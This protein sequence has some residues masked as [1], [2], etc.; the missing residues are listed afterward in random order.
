MGIFIQS[1]TFTPAPEGVHQAVCCDVVD[2]GM[3]SSVWDGEEKK[4]H[5]LRLSFQIDVLNGEGKPF[6]VS[7]KLTASTHEKAKMVAF[8]N[9]WRG[10]KMTDQEW[11]T[12]DLETLIGVNCM[13]QIIHNEGK[14]GN[15]YAN[16]Q[17]IMPWQ[18]KMGEPIQVRDYTRVVDRPD[19]DD[20]KREYA[21]AGVASGIKQAGESSRFERAGVA[22]ATAVAPQRN[23]VASPSSDIEIDEDEIPF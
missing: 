5:K 12:F 14:N 18:S 22:A 4:Q 2:L 9:S 3:E 11:R 10:K 7:Q 8:I 15:I 6:L 17:T 20:S 21:P 16:I 1:N 23:G 19:Y 13:L